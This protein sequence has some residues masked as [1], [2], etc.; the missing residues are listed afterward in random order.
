[1]VGCPPPAVAMRRRPLLLGQAAGETS[2]RDSRAAGRGCDA[3]SLLGHSSTDVMSVR[4]LHG[5]RH[6]VSFY[7]TLFSPAARSARVP[8]RRRRARAG[9]ARS[10]G[11]A[12]P[13]AQR[14]RRARRTRPRH[15]PAG[16]PPPARGRG[17]EQAERGAGARG[18]RV[19]A[20]MLERKERSR[21]R[22]SDRHPQVVFFS[23]AIASRQTRTPAP[24]S[25]SRISPRGGD[26]ARPMCRG[27]TSR[28]SA[29]AASAAP[30]APD[31]VSAP[32]CASVSV[33]STRWSAS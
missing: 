21:A 26:D 20:P 15:R 3:H 5:A 14:R 23:Y 31:V 30:S 9:S 24:P 16:A 18:L 4:P 22:G 6:G 12:R 29:S 11:R 13:A 17:G 1:M 10:R 2:A 33:S 25:P 19:R 8:S 7:V 28:K 27:L 32:P